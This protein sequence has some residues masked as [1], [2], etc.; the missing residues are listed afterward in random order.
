MPGSTATCTPDVTE[1]QTARG[2]SRHDG[3]KPVNGGSSLR[4]QMLIPARRARR[5]NDLELTTARRRNLHLPVNARRRAYDP[6][7]LGKFVA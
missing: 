2:W 4:L 6:L 5:R 3:A 1:R 7:R